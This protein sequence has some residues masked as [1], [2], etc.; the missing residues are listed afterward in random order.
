[1]GLAGFKESE[2]G[3]PYSA[4]QFLADLEQAW[5]GGLYLGIN[6]R[7]AS[8][9]DLSDIRADIRERLAKLAFWTRRNKPTVGEITLAPS[10][11]ETFRECATAGMPHSEEAQSFIH[12]LADPFCRGF[13][14]EQLEWF[15]SV[16]MERNLQ[17]EPVIVD[18]LPFR[19]S[20]PDNFLFKTV[21]EYPD[22]EGYIAAAKSKGDVL[23]RQL[24]LAAE[25]QGEFI[26]EFERSMNR[27]A[28]YA[29]FVGENPHTDLHPIIKV[30]V[31]ASLAQFERK[32]GF[33]SL[34]W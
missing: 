19:F 4:D 22:L 8:D 33:G 17:D 23:A 34:I 32:G 2:G 3:E 30:I 14:R 15:L 31:L 24:G 16:N 6:E 28:Q 7:F 12:L 21:L 5:G 29:R 11:A 9:P 10:I 18:S 13:L 27:F 1:M 25:R 26:S 20:G